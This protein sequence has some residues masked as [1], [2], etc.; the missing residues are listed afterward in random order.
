MQHEQR[1]SLMNM[2]FAL[3][4][5]A[6]RPQLE[7][8]MLEQALDT[9]VPDYI[10]AGVGPTPD[11]EWRM[12]AVAEEAIYVLRTA[13]EP[14]RSATEGVSIDCRR[15]P[16]DPMRSFVTMTVHY[17]DRDQGDTDV[18]RV[19]NFSFGDGNDLVLK[20]HSL[21]DKDPDLG[22][23]FARQLAVALA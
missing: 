14:D 4:G 8:T 23:Q 20:T 12:M 15:I 5:A 2:W 13:D 22:E 16:L 6:D 9:V 18:V 1:R 7:Q 17:E 11:G 10:F 21:N 19:W 3:D